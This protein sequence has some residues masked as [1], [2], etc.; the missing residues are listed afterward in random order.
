MN[1][2]STATLIATLTNMITIGVRVSPYPRMS[3]EKT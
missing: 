1:T 3:A 2:G